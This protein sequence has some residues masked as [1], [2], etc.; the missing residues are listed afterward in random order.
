M[1]NMKKCFSLLLVL[2][3]FLSLATVAYAQDY[4]VS[5]CTLQATMDYLVDHIGQRLAGTPNETMAAEYIR[6]MYEAIGYTDVVWNDQISR[7]AVAT[8]LVA[9]EGSGYIIGNPLP[10]SAAF[11][12]VEGQL[13]DLGT[14]PDLVVPEGVTGDII[15]AVRFNGAPNANNLNPA[16]ASLADENDINIV[17]VLLANATTFTVASVTG[18]PSVPC[19][20]TAGYFLE[21]AVAKADTFTHM[22]RYTSSLTNAVVATK[23]AP[24]GD[25]DL[26]IVISSHMDSVLASPGASDNASAVAANIELARRLFDVDLGN[27]EVRFAA[28]GSEENGGMA[29]SVWVANTLVNEGKAAISINLNIDMICSDSYTSATNTNN[30]LNAVS[31]D[32]NTAQFNATGFNLPSY[33]VT[34]E[35]RNIEWADGIDN[36]RIYRFGSSD[37]VSFATRGIE[38]GSMIIV[39][40]SADDIEYQDHNSRDN[41]EMNYSYDRLLMCT[42]LLENAVLKA[43]RQEVSKT[44][45]FY[46]DEKAGTITLHNAEQLFITYDTISGTFAGPA[47]SIPFTFTADKTVIALDDPLDY[48]INN[49]IAKGSGTAD[50]LNAV[51]N[52]QYSIFTAGMAVKY[53]TLDEVWAEASV[54]KLSGNKNELSITVYGLFSDGVI[55]E[56]AGDKMQINN[57]AAGQ[58]KVGAYIV[59]VDTK[60]N[61][62]IRACYIVN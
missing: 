5:G 9:F 18:T 34:D 32:I 1:K 6:D 10:N 48:A 29:G 28:V 30:P 31:M 51:R 44:A 61:D 25:P 2:C 15:G 57:N 11:P 52:A 16:L 55:K 47:G 27:I 24:G 7:G 20:T 41:L 21:R 54:A 45:K 35:A 38:A 58:Y 33:L 22:E 42:N 17:G 8:G 14:Y 43:A 46:A 62:Q 3:L 59:Y 39:T 50:N 56:I 4:D 12:K 53:I 13:V 19:I 26:I 36:V 40:D 37:H 23:P 49:V 60:G